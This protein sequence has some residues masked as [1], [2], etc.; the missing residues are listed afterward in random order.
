[1][2]NYMKKILSLLFLPFPLLSLAECKTTDKTGYNQYSEGKYSYECNVKNLCLGQRYGGDY[3]DFSTKKQLIQKHD[4]GKYPDLSKTKA[5]G[6]DQ[7]RKI[8]ED[9]QNKI[10]NCAIMK[11]KHKLH[12]TLIEEYKVSDRAKELLEKANATLEEQMEVEECVAPKDADKIYNFKDLLDS[13]TYEQCGYNMYMYYYEQAVSNNVS[14]LSSGKGIYTAS[15]AS[16]VLDTEKNKISEEYE[17]TRRTMDTALMMYQNF[18]KTYISHVLLEMIEL[19][20]TENKRY[21]G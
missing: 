11:S 16:A 3:W 5:I 18:E 1:M 9:T 20:F 19:E 7:V 6:F 4:M 12:K 2:M 21:I 13:L 10:M 8:Y 14:L 17:L 15:E